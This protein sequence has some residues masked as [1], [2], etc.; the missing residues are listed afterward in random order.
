MST[1][2][3]SPSKH[4]EKI[5]IKPLPLSERTS[6][7]QLTTRFDFGQ[8]SFIISTIS[9]LITLV[10]LILSMLDLGRLSYYLGPPIAFTTI[11][12]YLTTYILGRLHRRARRRNPKTTPTPKTCPPAYAISSILFA[13]F[14]FLCWLE[15]LVMT[16]LAGVNRGESF[17]GMG[18]V[19]VKG[20]LA[21]LVVEVIL[22]GVN[23]LL[24]GVV[25]L[26][27]SM[28]RR[29]FLRSQSSA[30]QLLARGKSIRSHKAKASSE[31]TIGSEASHV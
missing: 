15:P 30:G 7:E 10:Y 3:T 27:F 6:Q 26:F 31:T 18:E 13:C 19:F 25:I 12:F 20:N 9:S 11:L 29:Q 2:T 8:P 23:L 4:P 24:I 5:T 1:P 22:V 21:I 17:F 16:I 28:G 14:M